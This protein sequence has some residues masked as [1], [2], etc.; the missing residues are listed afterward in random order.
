M[1]LHDILNPIDVGHILLIPPSYN[2][3]LV[4]MNLLHGILESWSIFQSNRPIIMTR[5]T[6]FRIE[7]YH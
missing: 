4:L 5:N 1:K 6:N 2:L 3:Q 7:L